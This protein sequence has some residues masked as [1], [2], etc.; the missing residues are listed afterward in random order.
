MDATPS[1]LEPT[2]TGPTCPMCGSNDLTAK[3]WLGGTRDGRV[4]A[5]RVL[6]CGRCWSVF[7]GGQHEWD[8]CREVREQI[9]RRHENLAGEVA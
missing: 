2:T 1:D 3:D 4:H 6:L 8:Q 5:R 9:R 7:S